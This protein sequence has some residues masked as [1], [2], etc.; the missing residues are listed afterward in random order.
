MAEINSSFGSPVDTS[1]IVKA[2]KV[3]KYFGS[4]HVLK[5]IDLVVHKN[6]VVV[7][8]GPSGIREEHP[9]ALH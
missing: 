2:E 3:N 1:I 5:D 9:A 8:I 6:E 4:L 7:I